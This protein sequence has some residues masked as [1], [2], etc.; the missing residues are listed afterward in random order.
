MDILEVFT[1]NQHFVAMMNIINNARLCG[2]KKGHKHH[3]IPRCW[4][5]MMKLPVDNSKANLVMLSYEDHVKIHK[6]AYLCVKDNIMKGKLAYAYHRLTQGEIISNDAFIGERNANYGKR[7][8]HSDETKKHI[9]EGLK[10]HIELHPEYRDE[11]R[12]R[13]TGRKF[14]EES[15]LKKSKSLKGRVFNDEWRAKLS[16]AAKRR[17]ARNGGY[18]I[19][20]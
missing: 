2:N 11:C 3:I 8:K 16:E 10:K 15:K 20:K 18:A 7:H 12:I 19:A 9:S 6:L 5:K 14:S 4:F 1:Y 17:V 13:S